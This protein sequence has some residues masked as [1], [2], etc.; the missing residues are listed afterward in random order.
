MLLHAGIDTSLRGLVTTIEQTY[1]ILE[2][3]SSSKINA[4]KDVLLEIAQIIQECAQFIMKYLETK[5]S[6][7]PLIPVAFM[8][9]MFFTGSWL[10]KSVPSE[11]MTK[12]INYTWKLE[13]LM[14][15][16]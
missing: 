11:T 3:R 6:C 2:S 13:K 10:R 12:V 8:K 4:M 1:L 16:L 15:E 14:Q 9:L 7:M 5:T